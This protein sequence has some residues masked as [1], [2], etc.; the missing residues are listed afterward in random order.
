MFHLLSHDEVEDA[1]HDPPGVVHVE[2]D[3]LSELHRVELLCAEDDVPGAVLD[4]VPGHVPEL[5]VVRAGQDALDRPLG[6]L[7]GV[8]L[9]LV[10][11]HGPS[12]GVQLLS[13]VNLHQVSS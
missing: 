3:L 2:V 11:Q 12:L 10:G 6:E 7:A 5:Q 9:Q 8:V 1:P 4:V 13:P